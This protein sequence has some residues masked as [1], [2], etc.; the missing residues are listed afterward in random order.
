VKLI[1]YG[2]INEA[3]KPVGIWPTSLSHAIVVRDRR[4]LSRKGHEIVP[5]YVG[6]A[7]KASAPAAPLPA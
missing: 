3:N 1:G 5:V 6:N 4:N 2:V 7:V